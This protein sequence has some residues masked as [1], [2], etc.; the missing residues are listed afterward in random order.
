MTQIIIDGRRF[1]SPRHFVPRRQL[2]SDPVRFN[3]P[4]SSVDSHLGLSARLSLIH[5]CGGVSLAASGIISCKKASSSLHAAAD[6]FSF[7]L[8]SPPFSPLTFQMHF[9]SS[10]R[11]VAPCV[12]SEALFPCSGTAS[13]NADGKLPRPLRS[14]KVG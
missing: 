3:L 9:I 1:F 2:A 10:F 4:A 12:T 5:T 7:R 11:C 14:V 8:G 6:S 13:L